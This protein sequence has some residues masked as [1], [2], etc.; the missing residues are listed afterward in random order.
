MV[1]YSRFVAVWSGEWKAVRFACSFVTNITDH[2][3]G[4]YFFFFIVFSKSKKSKMKTLQVIQSKIFDSEKLVKQISIWKFLGKKIV[5]TN[6]CFDIL[7]LGH[8][9]YLI[10]ASE[11]GDLLIIGVNS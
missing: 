5:F 7:H 6:G 9:D 1:G 8:I 4:R 3:A 10:K 2:F 11:E